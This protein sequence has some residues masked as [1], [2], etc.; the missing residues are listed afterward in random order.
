M[1]DIMKKMQIIYID[2]QI[3]RKSDCQNNHTKRM[4]MKIKF[5]V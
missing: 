2:S 1:N 3:K 5:C 4:Q